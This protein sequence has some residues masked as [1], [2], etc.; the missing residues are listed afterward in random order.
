MDLGFLGSSYTW[1]RGLE[2]NTFRGTRLDRAL[3]NI[4]LKELFMEATIIHLPKLQSDHVPLLL[5]LTPPFNNNHS[6]SFMFQA[7]WTR[8]HSFRDLIQQT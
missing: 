7:A 4:P 3:A 5:R 2:E 1:M 8:H 6:S